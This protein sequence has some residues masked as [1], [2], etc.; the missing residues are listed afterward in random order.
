MNDLIVTCGSENWND[1]P[2]VGIF[3]VV[4]DHVTWIYTNKVD[5]KKFFDSLNFSAA[6]W[7]VTNVPELISLKEFEKTQIKKKE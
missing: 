7:D 3:H 4:C 5:A 2:D 1:I 6:F